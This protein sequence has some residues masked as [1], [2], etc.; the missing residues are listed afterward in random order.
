[1]VAASDHRSSKKLILARFDKQFLKDLMKIWPDKTSGQVGITQKQLAEGTD[2]SL[3]AISSYISGE[4]KPDRDALERLGR[5]FG[6]HF[7]IDWDNSLNMNELLERI[8]AFIPPVKA[9]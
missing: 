6:L 4:S 9:S 3:R 8:K 2:L 5:F 1:M 7:V